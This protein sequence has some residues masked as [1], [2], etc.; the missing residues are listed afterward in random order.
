M[1]IDKIVD[2]IGRTEFLMCAA[3]LTELEIAT[4]TLYC[5]NIDYVCY[6]SP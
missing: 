2:K 5:I 1:Y 6:R 4:I 3:A